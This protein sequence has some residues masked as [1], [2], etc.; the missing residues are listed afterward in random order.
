M[1]TE[2]QIQRVTRFDN[3]I[4]GLEG[5]HWYPTSLL[6]W[7]VMC[8]QRVKISDGAAE[9][10]IPRILMTHQCYIARTLMTPG[11][12]LKTTTKTR[13]KCENTKQHLAELKGGASN[14]SRGQQST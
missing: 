2:W 5:F 12:L 10:L 3:W 8:W 13:R 1:N 9:F 14:T 4:F 11:Q 7:F 6:V